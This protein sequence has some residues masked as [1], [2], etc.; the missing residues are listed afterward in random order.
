MLSSKESHGWGQKKKSSSL[1]WSRYFFPWGGQVN[2][3]CRCSLHSRGE[4]GGP[5]GQRKRFM[6]K[7]FLS[8]LEIQFLF[9]SFLKFAC[10]GDHL[11]GVLPIHRTCHWAKITWFIPVR[12]EGQQ[13]GR[14]GRSSPPLPHSP[15][16]LAGPSGPG[17]TRMLGSEA[18][19][20]RA[21]EE[22]GLWGLP[23]LQLL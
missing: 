3:Y 18:L 17:D 1:W 2:T 11:L 8:C 6:L 4:G 21:E 20:L 22:D 9:H 10:H 7:C 12:S 23:G 15:A 14:G 13:G 16:S 19:W 5:K